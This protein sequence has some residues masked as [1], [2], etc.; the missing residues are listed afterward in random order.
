MAAANDVGMG[1]AT[2]NSKLVKT[3]KNFLSR[4]VF[5]SRYTQFKCMTLSAQLIWM[6]RCHFHIGERV[7]QFCVKCN[8]KLLSFLFLTNGGDVARLFHLSYHALTTVLY[9]KQLFFVVL[10][11]TWCLQVTAPC[12]IFRVHFMFHWNPPLLFT[13]ASH[14][15][16]VWNDG[17]HNTHCVSA[18]LGS[19]KIPET[20]LLVHRHAKRHRRALRLFVREG[21]VMNCMARLS[22]VSQGS[23]LL[24][25]QRHSAWSKNVFVGLKRN[26][27]FVTCVLSLGVI[28]ALAHSRCRTKTRRLFQ[29]HN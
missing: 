20:N 8:R 26:A 6:R 5:F 21:D 25:S 19:R 22:V 1:G 7:V 23:F 18:R 3:E 4:T 13:C 28:V 2:W 12:V 10:C 24:L 9:Y 14:G 11:V 15:A 17:S 29:G 16:G 27:F